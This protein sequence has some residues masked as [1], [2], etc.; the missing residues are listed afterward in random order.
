M[1]GSQDNLFLSW[2][3]QHIDANIKRLRIQR[4]QQRI[5]A[6][7]EQYSY[8]IGQPYNAARLCEIISELSRLWNRKEQYEEELA[9]K[10][11]APKRLEEIQRAVYDVTYEAHLKMVN[12]KARK[13]KHKAFIKGLVD[14]KSALD[15][16]DPTLDVR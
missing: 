12:A 13:E 2:Y 3:G 10:S 11:E 1:L 5:Q 15:E 9:G 6:L 7:Q 14:I 8:H 4:L 16:W